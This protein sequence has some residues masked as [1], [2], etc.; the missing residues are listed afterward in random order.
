ML[1]I[2]SSGIFLNVYV[3]SDWHLEEIL[4]TYI[5]A[6]HGLSCWD[7]GRGFVHISSL[8]EEINS[9]NTLPHSYFF[10]NLQI[11]KSDDSNWGRKRVINVGI[12][13]ENISGVTFIDFK[14]EFINTHPSY[15]LERNSRT[16]MAAALKGSFA[17]D[18]DAWL[19]C[20]VTQYQWSMENI[21][22]PNRGLAGG[23]AVS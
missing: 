1:S 18:I 3:N 6:E 15:P 10:Y 12:H 7:R 5:M 8:K 2:S 23:H 21:R 11:S 4:S 14:W 13:V 19:R 16:L 22:E 20:P 17:V 9:W